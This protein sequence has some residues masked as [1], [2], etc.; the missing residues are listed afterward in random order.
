MK[1][2]QTAFIILWSIAL[3]SGCASIPDS[4]SPV[5]SYKE[6]LESREKDG[7]KVSVAALGREESIR[8]FGAPLND[9]GIQPI[10]LEIENQSTVMQWLLPIGID[11]NYFP[12]YEASRR[13]SNVSSRNERE[14]YAALSQQAIKYVVRPGE[15]TTGFVY[16]HA[17][18]GMKAL[19]VRLH[20]ETA[21]HNFHFV[22]PVPGI[23]NNYFDPNPA[24]LYS[25]TPTS[26]TLPEL[27]EWIANLPCCA[28][29]AESA[30]GDPINMVFV[31]DL[32]TLREALISNH[33]DVT[34]PISS[35]S[36]RR[37]ISAFIFGS[38]YRYAPI[39]PLYFFEREQDIAFQ[40]ARSVIDER[41]HM[42]LWL[43]PV[44]YQGQSVWVGQASRDVGVKFSGR[45]WP[46]TTH[47]IDPDMDDARFYI[48]QELVDTGYAG[49]FG[50][51]LGHHPAP[52][53][54]PHY[55]AEG[56]PYF[57]D[58]HLVVFFLVKDPVTPAKIEL[59]N[60]DLPEGLFE[61]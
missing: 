27:R 26:L 24:T 16:A 28:V 19:N 54:S 3:L 30:P 36:I 57:T 15:K 42:R 48:V 6:R 17:D 12:P 10:W 59:L 20:G 43:A 35:A 61:R 29:N 50:F 40:K 18:E 5:A 58:G 49:S 53:E 34:A 38:R 13:A 44:S 31:S 32:D 23:P 14:L 33:W 45:F 25:Q 55:N 39:S 21:E 1:R 22:V 46:P 47:I 56:D 41:N 9:I 60:W 51:V 8:V 2:L 7:L 11:D 52:P 37:M 4:N